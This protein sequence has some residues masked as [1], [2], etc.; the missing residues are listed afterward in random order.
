M[1]A[2]QLETLPEHL[3]GARFFYAPGGE[4][5]DYC[6]PANTTDD[7]SQV[8]ITELRDIG[9]R[10]AE[11]PRDERGL[12][13]ARITGFFERYG[14]AAKP[15]IGVD[16]AGQKAIDEIM[17]VTHEPDETVASH[18][19]LLGFTYVVRK[20]D[21]TAKESAALEANAVH[22]LSHANHPHRDILTFTRI[23]GGI[24]YILMRNGFTERI[25]GSRCGNYLEEG[26]AGLMEHLYITDELGLRNGF[27]GITQPHK[28]DMEPGSTYLLPG[29][30]LH[31]GTEEGFVKWLRS[32]HP[33]YG[34][35]LL[36]GKD[37]AIFSAMIAARKDIEGMH[38]FTGRIDALDAGLYSE[39]RS[40][41][42][43]E[44]RFRQATQYIINR[45][46]DGNAQAAVATATEQ[47]STELIAA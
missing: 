45:L 22:E 33:A 11:L 10:L 1:S 31:P 24:G 35:Q 26:F 21:E 44:M 32:A 41:P 15:F 40:H 36:M 43:D 47:D 16:D 39:L 17:Q 14:L 38:E 13:I 37:P 8:V 28:L 2:Q 12:N 4:D 27:L 9:V 23:G 46:Y 19:P 30:Y 5:T 25:G 18:F 6:I 20:P 34:L 3:Q 7:S 29:S 42:Y